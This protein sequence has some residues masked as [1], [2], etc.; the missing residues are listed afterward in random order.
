M[1]AGNENHAFE[2]WDEPLEG[3]QIQTR[4]RLF[5]LCCNERKATGNAAGLGDVFLSDSR[6]QSK[7]PPIHGTLSIR[8]RTLEAEIFSTLRGIYCCLW[9][10]GWFPRKWSFGELGTLRLQ[11]LRFSLAAF[12]KPLSCRGGLRV[13]R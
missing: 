8:M 3:W 13:R 11:L 10:C 9:D 4:Y 7:L 12:P 6:N 1:P 5:K 2:E